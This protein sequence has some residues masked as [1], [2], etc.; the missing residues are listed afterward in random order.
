MQ[1]V[2]VIQVQ[3][4]EK[5]MKTTKESP[6]ETYRGTATITGIL[7]I[8]GTVAGILSVVFTGSILGDPNYLIKVSANANQIALGA[9]CVLI[10][11]LALAMVPVVIFPILKKHNEVLALGY[12]VFRGG[13]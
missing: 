6:N 13:A 3:G 10:M 8:I 9:L 2:P 11:G 12:A 5:K 7:F 1:W 4:S